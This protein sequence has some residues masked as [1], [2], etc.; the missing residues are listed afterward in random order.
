M[1]EQLQATCRIG[2]AASHTSCMLQQ[3]LSMR[4]RMLQVC[5]RQEMELLHTWQGRYSMGRWFVP[6]TAALC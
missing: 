4:G 6:A 3:Y 2:A 5:E 1:G